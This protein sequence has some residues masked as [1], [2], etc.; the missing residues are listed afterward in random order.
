MT[1]DSSLKYLA[2]MLMLCKCAGAKNSWD[3]R[4]TSECYDT[5]IAFSVERSEMDI[6][7]EIGGT[8]LTESL[9]FI[10]G[11]TMYNTTQH[12]VLVVPLF[13]IGY[14]YED[15]KLGHFYG[16]FG[17]TFRDTKAW[18]V[19]KTV[20]ERC[21]FKTQELIVCDP[22]GVVSV[23]ASTIMVSPWMNPNKTSLLD[24][25]CRPVETDNNRVL[26][27]F[28]V[29]TCGTKSRIGANYVSYENE[30]ILF[31]DVLSSGQAFITRDSDFRLV[32]GCTYRATGV[33]TLSV[34]TVPSG[35]LQAAGKGS[36]AQKRQD[37][38]RK[39]S[40]FKPIS[41]DLL[42]TLRAEAGSPQTQ[43]LNPVPLSPTHDTPGA[44]V[45]M[46]VL[47]VL[48]SV[49]G[50]SLAVIKKMCSLK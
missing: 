16:S 11:Y 17:V 8:P 35:G 47:L 39:R 28:T 50:I 36:V 12:K 49:L 42:N 34:D 2:A 21:M 3:P 33:A 41:N 6:R 26:F 44:F 10:R 31:R 29:N 48:M 9:A 7:W 14:R 19:S 5:S 1:S 13:S 43:Q 27:V 18:N 30:I 23:V 24:T 25:N 38:T 15:I 22:T 45:F 37:L 32:I 40:R 20:T 4:V 46:A